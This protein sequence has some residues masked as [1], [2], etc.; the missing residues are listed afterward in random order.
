MVPEF[1]M[2]VKALPKVDILK[3]LQKTQ[4]GYHVIFVKEIFLQ[5]N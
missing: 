3:I 2:A 4:F 1:A 5:N